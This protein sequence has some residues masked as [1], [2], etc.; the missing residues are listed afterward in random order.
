[1]YIKVEGFW[2]LLGIL[3]PFRTLQCDY[4]GESLAV[5]GQPL[6]ERREA[7]LTLPDGTAVEAVL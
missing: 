3:D 7:S 4:V 6:V 5:G 2:A 1:M